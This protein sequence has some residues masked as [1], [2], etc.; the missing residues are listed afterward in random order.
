MSKEVEQKKSEIL[1]VLVEASGFKP[2]EIDEMV[3]CLLEYLKTRQ[4][5]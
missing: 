5:R 4:D 1:P 3:T 2:C